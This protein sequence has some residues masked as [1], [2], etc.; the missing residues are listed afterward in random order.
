MVAAKILGTSGI[1]SGFLVGVRDSAEKLGIFR[2]RRVQH[3]YRSFLDSLQMFRHTSC[4]DPRDKVY[5]PLCLAPDDVRRFIQPDYDSKTV[6]DVYMDVVQYYLAQPGHE[7]DF[8]GYALYQD[9]AQEVEMPKSTKWPEGVKST[10]PSWVP[11]FSANINLAPIPKILHVPEEPQLP[12][13]KWYDRHDTPR[14]E[15]LVAAYRPLGDTPSRSLIEGNTLSV[16]GVY[17]DLL[18]DIIPETGPNP[19]AIQ[20][21]AREKGRKWAVDSKHKYFTGESFGDAIQHTCVL[22]LVY[23]E[24]LRP[25]QRGGKRD[26]AFMKRPHAEL[27]LAEFRLQ[28]NARNALAKASVSRNLG[29]SQK[30]CLLM[31]PITAVVGDLIWA[32][33]GGQALYVLRLVNRE[34]NQYR[35]LGE[36]Y[37][38]GLMDGE[39]LRRLKLGE[40]RMDD[41]SLI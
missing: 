4:S 5:A 8:L 41:I 32:L 11:N 30:M 6:L 34:K 20:A 22:D 28:M 16:N 37:G 17:I 10:L 24:Q 15:T 7:L 13:F 2:G 19:E 31:V 1:D 39:I 18:K 38:H 25:S 23:D 36:C 14:N 33:A 12:R 9:G 35:F 3:I 40:A 21:T 26:A 27:S 29:L